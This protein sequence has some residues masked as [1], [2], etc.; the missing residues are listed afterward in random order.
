MT[1]CDLDTLLSE[2]SVKGKRVFVRADL[3]V[4]MRGDQVADRA[5]IEASLPTL[6]RLTATLGSLVIGLAVAADAL[7]LGEDPTFEKECLR[8]A[9][10]HEFRRM[11]A[12]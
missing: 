1:V 6:R 7:G 12:I 2:H 4:P 11:L 3:N 8:R 5:R 10:S 9:L